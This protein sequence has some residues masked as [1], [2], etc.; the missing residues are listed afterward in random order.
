M[1]FKQTTM[2]KC[3]KRTDMLQKAKITNDECKVIFSM[4]F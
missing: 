1:K 4:C 3:I 2:Y